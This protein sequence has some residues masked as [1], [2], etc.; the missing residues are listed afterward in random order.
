MNIIEPMAFNLGPYLIRQLVRPDNP[1]WAQYAVFLGPVRIGACFSMP[2]IG[3]CKWL[4]AQQREQTFYAY[5][6]EELSAN[7]RG[8]AFRHYP[9]R[10]R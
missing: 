6:S 2:D 10:C 9:K 3:A 5:S 4:E 7:R 8:K 1:A